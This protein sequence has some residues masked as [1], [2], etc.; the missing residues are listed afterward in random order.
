MEMRRARRVP[1]LEP[2]GVKAKR[3][4]TAALAAD[5]MRGSPPEDTD[6]NVGSIF[7]VGEV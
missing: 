7:C 2:P 4:K 5:E 3:T 1:L 6:P